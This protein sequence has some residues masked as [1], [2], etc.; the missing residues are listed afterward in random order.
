LGIVVAD[1]SDKGV[2]ASIMMALTRSILRAEIHG[3]TTPGGILRAVNRH[4][5]EMNDSG[6]FVTIVFGLLEPRKRTFTYARAGHEFPLLF[7]PSGEVP[8]LPRQPGQP[9]GILPDPR[10]D[11]QVITLQPGSVLLLFTDG[12]PDAMNAQ[13][14]FFG[15]ERLHN[16][17]L[18]DP[19]ASSQEICDGVIGTIKAFQGLNAQFDD[20]TLVVIRA[21]A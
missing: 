21:L 16:S 10:I 19:N 3:A 7:A 4:V 12:L 1:V 8:Q 20:M 9:V 13:G 6:M 18:H 11:E 5:L 2:P 14:D 15:A 17:V